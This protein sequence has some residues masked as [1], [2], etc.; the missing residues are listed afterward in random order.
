[1]RLIKLSLI[2]ALMAGSALPQCG[3]LVVNPVTGLF[4]C[5]GLVNPS[6]GAIGGSSTW[7]SITGT[8]SAQTDLQNAL[9]LK[10]A[11]LTF[12]APLSRTTN[13]VSCPTCVITSGSYA[14]PSWITSIGGAKVSGA[15]PTAT[16]L[17]ANGTNC[18]A[19]S[20]PL[21]V[22]ASGN[23]EGC[24]VA[25]GGGG[26]VTTVSVATANGVSGTV[27]N[28]TTTP[29]ITLSLGAITPTSVAASGTVSGSNLSGTNTGDQ[30]T[31]T[32]N[33]GTAT[34]LQTARNINGVAFNGTANITV[35][36][37]LPA[38]PA[39]C[40]GGEY[41]TDIAA[42][43]ALTCAA[44]SGGAHTQNTDS[45]TTQTSFQIDSTNSGPR[46]KNNAGTMQ[47]RNAADSA[48]AALEA[49]TVTAS[50]TGN[51][52]TATALA[53]N[54]AN[55]AAGTFPLGVSASGAAEDCTALPT[56]ITGT[57][58]Q[59][60]ASGATGAV[61]LSF[62]AG[63]V[64]LPGTTTGTF[65]G[66][67]TGNA[68]TATALATARAING[69]NFDGTAPITIT[70]NLPSDP[71]ACSAGQ[72]ATD[73]AADGT[74]TCGTP[75]GGGSP[76]GTGSELQFRGGATTF[77]ALDNSS[78][79][80]AGEL[81]IATTPTPG[82]TRSVFA[83][84]SALNGGNASANGGTF[85]SLNAPSGYV[86]D[87]IRFELNN[88]AA[89]AVNRLGNITIGAGNTYGSAGVSISNVS[90]LAFTNSSSGANAGVRVTGSAGTG[91]GNFVAIRPTSASSGADALRINA[92][93]RGVM[94][95]QTAETASVAN[96]SLGVF[97]DTAGSGVTRQIVQAGDAQGSTNLFEVRGFDATLG[98]GA[99]LF[100]VQSGGSFRSL[101]TGS[102]PACASGIRGEYWYT[103]GGAGVKD[104]VAVCAKDASDVYAWRT[105]Y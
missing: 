61:T 92:D 81:R 51:A 59:I 93:Q 26:T 56:T 68:S 57:A 102:R 84:G 2:T 17:A 53:A 49:S 42:N 24:T 82:A 79:P 37:N 29:A 105:I 80:N 10:D 87:F 100:E 20:Y 46:I 62:P 88:A 67:V 48:L 30:T 31:I 77:S 18:S 50:L 91:G 95:G 104:D 103:Q 40:P 14:D 38:D 34:A 35:T 89:F 11:V 9:N 27:A 58:N 83:L 90:A 66:A 22:D 1:M 4:D 85:Y 43:G 76:G 52:S 21:G 15:V 60:T 78:V 96:L 8:L 44:V 69:V 13:A 7:G 36:A 75:S 25:S 33:A 5:A 70:A 94:I 28:A 23:A 97:D 47:V 73:I 99:L 19:G 39:A 86:G 3:T 6:G 101:P 55:C 63:G 98:S 74:L 54:G 12:N 72:F 41:V 32:G 71:A 64:T 65:S 45:G 16:A